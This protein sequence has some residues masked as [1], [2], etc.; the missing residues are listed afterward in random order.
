MGCARK[1]VDGARRLAQELQQLQ[2]LR[3][4]DRLADP[5][6]L[7]V[8]PVRKLPMWVLHWFLQKN[9]RAL[10]LFVHDKVVSR[11]GKSQSVSGYPLSRRC[12]PP[13]SANVRLSTPPGQATATVSQL[14]N[15]S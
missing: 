6:N 14:S 4:R 15:T 1:R 11:R 9:L 13:A 8:N 3:T 5:R 12:T 10:Q 2:T 7:L